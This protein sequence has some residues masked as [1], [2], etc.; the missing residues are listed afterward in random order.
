MKHALLILTF[1]TTGCA[2]QPSTY[3]DKSTITQKNIEATGQAAVEAAK[4][5]T[6]HNVNRWDGSVDH[7]GN[8]IVY[9]SDGKIDH[10]ASIKLKQAMDHEGERSISEY[11][12]DQIRREAK[13][14][15]K[16]NIRKFVNKIF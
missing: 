7:L 9:K 15:S 5:N 3:I 6:S 1:C 13:Y 12:L 10:R 8:P 4:S 16:Q 14:K 2:Y 11:T